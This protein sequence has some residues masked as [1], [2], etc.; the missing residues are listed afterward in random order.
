MRTYTLTLDQLKEFAE[1]V[2]EASYVRACN[3][4][5]NGDNPRDVLGTEAYHHFKCQDIER[6]LFWLEGKR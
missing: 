1:R 4:Y 5:D 3:A 6:N 2:S